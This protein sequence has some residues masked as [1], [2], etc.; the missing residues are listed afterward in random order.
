MIMQIQHLPQDKEA[1]SEQQWGYTFWEFLTGNFWY[2]LG[3]LIILAIFLY[4]RSYFKR[5]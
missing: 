3:I 5:H 4:A 2:I 1:T